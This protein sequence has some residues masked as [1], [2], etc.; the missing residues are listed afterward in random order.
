MEGYELQLNDSRKEFARRNGGRSYGKEEGHPSVLL[1]KR[2][3]GKTM[4]LS[5]GKLKGSGEDE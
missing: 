4:L 2:E 1:W 3:R 5:M